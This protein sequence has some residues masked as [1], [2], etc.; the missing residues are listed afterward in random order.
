MWT[1]VGLE[2][3]GNR[4]IQNSDNVQ[5]NIHSA[6]KILTTSSKQG[7]HLSAASCSFHEMML[8]RESSTHITAGMK[9]DC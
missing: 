1:E 5:Q 6:V 7:V 3:N 8:A 9:N 4:L 2:R